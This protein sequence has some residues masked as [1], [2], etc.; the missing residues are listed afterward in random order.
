MRPGVTVTVPLLV[1]LAL[2]CSDST[3]VVET[4]LPGTWTASAF[5]L[6]VSDT[7]AVRDVLSEG[8]QVY[9]TLFS[10]ASFTAEVRPPPPPGVTIQ[11][12]WLPRQITQGSWEL[13]GPD[14]LVLTDDWSGET[15]DLDVTMRETGLSVRARDV[16]F[17]LGFGTIPTSFRAE[18]SKAVWQ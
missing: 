3:G 17:D 14:H 2:A 11:T 7:P 12:Q 8:Y 10:G 5:V 13:R 16:G 4:D 1:G 6:S 9:L 18:L 15:I